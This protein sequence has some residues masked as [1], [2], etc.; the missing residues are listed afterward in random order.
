[1][2]R[3]RNTEEEPLRSATYTVYADGSMVLEGE[4]LPARFE[5][6]ERGFVKVLG[7][8][9][10]VFFLALEGLAA[11]QEDMGAGYLL[12]G[13]LL[14]LASLWLLSDAYVRRICVDGEVIRY[15]TSLGRRREFTVS[16]IGWMTLNPA[17]SSRVYDREGRLLLRY[18]SNMRNAPY[19]IWFL[20]EHHIPI[21]G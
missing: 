2:G 17:D 15:T 20:T 4:T 5:L 6:R 14:V 11:A 13:G 3:K 16:D 1:M 7:W 8:V 19:F 10:L 12:A 18:E 9:C 21:R